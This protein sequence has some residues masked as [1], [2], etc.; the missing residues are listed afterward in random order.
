MSLAM[1]YQ[2]MMKALKIVEMDKNLKL[3]K[4]IYSVLHLISHLMVISLGKKIKISI[5]KICLQEFTGDPSQYNKASR[6]D[7][8]HINWKERSTFVLICR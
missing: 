4:S 5:L 6:R 2:I 7:K 8:T 3:K 1:Q